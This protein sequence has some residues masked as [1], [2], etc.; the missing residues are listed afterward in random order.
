MSASMGDLFGYAGTAILVIT[1]FSNQNGRLASE[2]WRYPGLNLLG[3]LLLI[4]S[5][6]FDMNWPS[7]AFELFWSAISVYGLWKG[8]RRT[9]RY[10]EG[11]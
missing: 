10:D 7:F 4:V 3:S 5:L 11:A 2:D 9:R 6:Q 1:Y 8:L